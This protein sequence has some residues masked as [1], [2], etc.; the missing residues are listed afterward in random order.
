MS[1]SDFV[2]REVAGSGAMWSES[3]M[4]QALKIETVFISV[5]A[6]DLDGWILSA[7]WV[8]PH[9][10]RKRAAIFANI[11]TFTSYRQQGDREG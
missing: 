3:K 10:P 9:R 8:K 6:C 7:Y 4:F 2:G 5:N 1:A 11:V